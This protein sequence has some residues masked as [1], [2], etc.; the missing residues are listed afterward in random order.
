MSFKQ[1]TSSRNGWSVVVAIARRFSGTE[2]PCLTVL[3][4]HRCRALL[5]GKLLGAD[6]HVG[7]P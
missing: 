2:S 6:L 4:L 7:N 5:S 3:V 1:L